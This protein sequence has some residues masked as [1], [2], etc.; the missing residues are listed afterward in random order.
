MNEKKSKSHGERLRDQLE[1]AVDSQGG[2]VL[3]V[4]GELLST[5]P[6][7]TVLSV[8]LEALAGLCAIAT[9]LH[10]GILSIDPQIEDRMELILMLEQANDSI[11]DIAKSLKG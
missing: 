2:D 3:D 9:G 8:K 1:R 10:Y 4:P 5:G 11:A 7:A 6:P